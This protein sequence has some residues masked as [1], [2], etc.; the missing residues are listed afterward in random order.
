MSLP[1]G[2]LRGVRRVDDAGAHWHATL[3]CGHSIDR[4]KATGRLGV[5]SRCRCLDCLSVAGA[6][7]QAMRSP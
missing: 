4:P 3:V 7:S 2:P 5:F 1:R 6:S